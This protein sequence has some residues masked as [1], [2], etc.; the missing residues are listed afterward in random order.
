VSRTRRILRWLA[1]P[2]AGFVALL[3]VSLAGLYGASRSEAGRAWLA[4][5]LEAAVTEPGGLELRIG[6]LDGRLPP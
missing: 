4:R 5:S 2:A 3:L 1:I 6:R